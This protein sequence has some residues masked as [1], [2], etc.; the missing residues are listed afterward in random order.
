[1]PRA[2][3]VVC[4]KVS[5][6][7][8]VGASLKTCLSLAVAFFA[9]VGAARA[10]DFEDSQTIGLFT[11][12]QAEVATSP[13][14][15]PIS[16][17]AENVTV[18]TAEDILRLNAHSL[19]EVLQT[20]P[21]IQL[22]FT[23]RPPGTVGFFNIQGAVNTTV[24]ILID[25]IRQNDFDQDVA[26]PGLIP[27]Q[28][29]ERIEIIK[30][31]ASGSWGSA[32]GGV[33]NV[34]TKSPTPERPFTGLVSSS[35]GSRFTSDSRAELSGTKNSFG[36]YLTG[37]HLRS[38]GL[39]PGTG[40]HNENLYG[41]LS[42]TLVSGGNATLGLSRTYQEGGEGEGQIPQRFFL[43]Q[44]GDEGHGYGFLRF[45]QPLGDQ[46]NL[47]VLGYATE[48][49]GHLTNSIRLQPGS[50]GEVNRYSHHESTRGVNANLSW[51]DSR[52]NL[53]AG[54]EYLHGH[55]RLRDLHRSAPPFY[56]RTWDSFAGYLNGTYSVGKLAILPGV[57]FDSTGIS[58]D[59]MSY[60][61]G[62]TY[63]V[64]E[65][66]TL[67]AYGAR[68]FSVPTLSVDTGA[69]KVW[70]AQGGVET[71]VVPLLWLK[72]TYFFNAVSNSASMA[73]LPTV[74]TTDEIRQGV[75]LEAR[76][77]PFYGFALAGGYTYLYAEDRKTHKRL[78]S[79]NRHTVPPH[80]YKLALNYDRS[81]C[82]VSGALTGSGVAWNAPAPYNSM[83]RNGMIWDF[84]LNWKAA[85]W[86]AL[87]PELFF[88]AHNLFNG[89]QT[90]NNIFFNTAGRWYE[91][92]ARVRF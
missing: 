3:N 8:T 74:T 86:N 65:D 5:S 58:G 33:V 44:E 36:Y 39:T 83:A 57:R 63:R 92:G 7:R 51:G 72:G 80:V 64:A 32:L 16:K 12:E 50:F 77:T 76:T 75:E 27:V 2:L 31:A 19:A 45:Q 60:T 48:L 17:I 21:G 41:K 71:G 88:S 34:V 59:H 84:S 40:G 56:D 14:P 87:A 61:L 22:E 18:I 29:I 68:G 54:G 73:E 43:R 46:L 79:D 24:L 25:G 78:Q 23:G 49:Q 4:C 62:V 47:E 66:T 90:T 35:I 91:G 55:A 85:S 53:V 52:N 28:Q 26:W 42:Y 10:Y 67:R 15:R 38:D 37:G 20:V 11:D 81:A 89:D 6:L 13:I 82:G 69:Q 1:M 30:G 70:T 9:T